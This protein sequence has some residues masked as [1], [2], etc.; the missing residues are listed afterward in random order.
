MLQH[1]TQLQAFP[2]SS[3]IRLD[4]Q[5]TLPIWRPSPRAHCGWA[6]YM[7]DHRN[8]AIYAKPLP[9]SQVHLGVQHGRHS[10]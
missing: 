7:L 9:P 1:S 10:K 6:A 5:F 2:L 4:S 8:E 3:A